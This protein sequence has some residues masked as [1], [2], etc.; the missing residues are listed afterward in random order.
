MKDTSLEKKEESDKT[1][2]VSYTPK[3]VKHSVTN[4]NIILLY[5]YYAR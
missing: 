3:C 2:A 1:K 5:L 4:K